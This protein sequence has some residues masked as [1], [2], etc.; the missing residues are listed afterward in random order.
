MLEKHK[1]Y[2]LTIINFNMSFYLFIE[3][4]FANNEKSFLKSNGSILSDEKT[5]RYMKQ[6]LI[7]YLLTSDNKQK[8]FLKCLILQDANSRN[9]NRIVNFLNSSLNYT[10]IVDYATTRYRTLNENQ[11]LDIQSSDFPSFNGQSSDFPSFDVIINAS[12]QKID[13]LWK[14]ALEK[15]EPLLIMKV[16][17]FIEQTISFT[18]NR[19]KI[20]TKMLNH[21]PPKETKPCKVDSPGD[22]AFCNLIDRLK[23]K[24]NVC[25]SKLSQK[26]AKLCYTCNLD[27]A[28]KYNNIDDMEFDLFYKWILVYNR[29]NRPIETLPSNETKLIFTYIISDDTK[30]RNEFRK[31]VNILSRLLFFLSFHNILQI[32]ELTEEFIEK[33]KSDESADICIPRECRLDESTDICIPRECRLNEEDPVVNEEQKASSRNYEEDS[34]FH[35]LLQLKDFIRKFCNYVWN[36]IIDVKGFVRKPKIRGEV[37]N[38]QNN[39]NI[40]DASL[41]HIFYVVKDMDKKSINLSLF[42]N[43]DK[44]HQEIAT[45]MT[46]AMSAIQS[47]LAIKQIVSYEGAVVDELALLYKSYKGDWGIPS[48][49]A[50]GIEETKE[51]LDFKCNVIMQW[52]FMYVSYFPTIKH[53]ERLMRLSYD[54][55]NKV[56]KKIYGTEQN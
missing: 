23:V 27:Y 44:S 9:I 46:L 16:L 12:I 53:V 22:K 24:Y 40:I 8:S 20:L 15:K 21:R 29:T 34:S 10:E 49:I 26:D 36:N 38:H 35:Y 33:I 5:P 54:Q 28:K 2:F 42:G 4:L 7:I 51:T 52:L 56:I 31:C 37:V 50:I 30:E 18:N 6:S 48:C 19:S 43:I 55:I 17:Y 45:H 1:I 39:L 32:N 25:F 47:L 14:M 3:E 11:L 41:Q 13:N